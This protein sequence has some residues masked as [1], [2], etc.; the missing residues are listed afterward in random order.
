MSPATAARYRQVVEDFLAHLGPGRAQAPL[1]SVSPRD[2]S[3]MRDNLRRKGLSARACNAVKQMLN[4]PFEAAKRLGFIPFNPCGAVDALKEENATARREPFTAEE[5]E[6]LLS[7][8]QGEWYGAVL[9]GWTTGLRL[10]DVA[11]LTWSCIDLDGREPLTGEPMPVIRVITRKTQT[12]LVLPTHENFTS[13]LTSQPR[14]VGRAPLFPS[15]YGKA[16]GGKYGLSRQFGAIVSEAGITHRVT[17]RHGEGRTTVSKSFHSLRHGLVSALAN[18]GIPPDVRK[19]IVGH[20]SDK[21]H[22]IYS[23]HTAELLRSALESLPSVVKRKEAA[24]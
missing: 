9:V 19:K 13:W 2:I 17:E 15:L 11:S 21:I 22:A 24:E 3:A 7:V 1:G 20:S 5:V 12:P 8:A 18:A 14:G 16:T 10:S 4:I 23:Q 6:R